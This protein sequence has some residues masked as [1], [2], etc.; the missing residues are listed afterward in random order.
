MKQG[1]LNVIDNKQKQLIHICKAQLIEKGELSEESYRDM[2]ERHYG[3]RSCVYL[4]YNQAE[5][6]INDMIRLGAEI[7]RKRRPRRPQAPNITAIVSPQELAKIEHLKADIKWRF[8]DGYDRWLKKYL[9]KD[10]ITTSREASKVIE[11][12]KGMLARQQRQEKF[13]GVEYFHDHDRSNA[14]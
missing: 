10:R 6:F 3:V 13:E 1:F 4:T 2:M 14:F 7:K 12:L 11:A 5:A 8:H 9:K